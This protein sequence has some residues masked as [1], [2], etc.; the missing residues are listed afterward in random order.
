MAH[1]D[2]APLLASAAW[3][4]VPGSGWPVDPISISASLIYRR[5]RKQPVQPDATWRDGEWLPGGWR[6]VHTPGHTPGHTAFYRAEEGLLIAGDA[7]GSLERGQIRFPAPEYADNLA[8]ARQSVRR[9]AELDPA[10]ICFGHGPEARG[11]AALL[12]DLARASR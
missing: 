9:L 1:E 10:V 4:S 5:W 11:A 12:R 2:E 3:R 6:A 7:I 8:L